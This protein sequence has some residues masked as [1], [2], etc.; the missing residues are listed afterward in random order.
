[1]QNWHSFLFDL[2]LTWKAL[3]TCSSDIIKFVRLHT[4]KMDYFIKPRITSI[5]KN[6]KGIKL[7]P[8]Q[9]NCLL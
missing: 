9:L 7:K 6:I 2:I 4:Y 8:T 5:K 3:L 1:M